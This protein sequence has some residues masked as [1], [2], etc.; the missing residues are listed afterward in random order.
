[1]NVDPVQQVCLV[2]A[3]WEKLPSFRP[4]RYERSLCI[5]ARCVRLYMSVNKLEDRRQA[6]GNPSSFEER[7]TVIYS[8]LQFT[9]NKDS[10]R[11]VDLEEAEG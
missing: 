8:V 11:V 9:G 10:V 1:M 6:A 5:N 2:E 7:V 3:P 4:E